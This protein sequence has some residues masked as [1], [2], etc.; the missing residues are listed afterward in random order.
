[1]EKEPEGFWVTGPN[2]AVPIPIFDVGQAAVF[3][4]QAEYRRAKRLYEAAR[5][6]AESEVQSAR[7]RVSA[8]RARVRRYHDLVLPLR[9]RIL[10]ETQLQYNGMFVGVF[11]L[12]QAKKDE[13]DAAIQEVAA[14]RDYWVARV[15]LEES[16]GTR[17]PF[18]EPP[19]TQPATQPAR[20]DHSHHHGD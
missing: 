14:L 17:L 9:R 18:S 8:A 10:Q 2:L 5:S 1:A 3:R 4:A 13:L 12:I 7:A 19:T 20:P 6:D 15:D 16:V 11:E